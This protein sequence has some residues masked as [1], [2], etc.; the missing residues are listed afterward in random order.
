MKIFIKQK[1]GKQ[2][3]ASLFMDFLF[4]LLSDWLTRT[5]RD[6]TAFIECRLNASCLQIMSQQPPSETGIGFVLDH[7]L[8]GIEAHSEEQVEKEQGAL[9]VD[10][11]EMAQN[12]GVGG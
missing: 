10:Y 12:L 11:R 7:P 5:W 9:S 1:A 8:V 2:P 3:Y 6:S 4:L